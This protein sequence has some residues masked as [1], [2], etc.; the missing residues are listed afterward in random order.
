MI[1][2]ISM[3]VVG[4]WALAAVLGPLLSLDASGVQLERMLEPPSAGALLGHDEL[5]RPLAARLLSGSGTSFLVAVSVVSLSLLVGTTLGTFSAWCGGVVDHVLVRIIDVFLAFPGILLA[6]ALAGI[7]GPGIENVVLALS[8]V[9]WVGF[10]RLTR[11]QTLSL[12]HAEHVMAA[13]ALG[14][15]GPAIVYRHVLPLMAAPLIV[16]ATFAVAAVIIS[17]AGLSFLGLG[18]Q[19]PQASWGSIIREGT[20]YMLVAPHLVVIPAATLSAVVLAINLLGDR[21]RDVLDVRLN[22]VDPG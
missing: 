18:V 19:P 14:A 6:I 11:A 13:V 21:L 1:A 9:G 2:R 17:E 5:G 7:L 15:R 10:A 8:V 20:R 3:V 4:L 16:E 22:E 12:K